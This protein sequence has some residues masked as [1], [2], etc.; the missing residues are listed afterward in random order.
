[1]DGISSVNFKRK[2]IRKIKSASVTYKLCS[3][4]KS[5]IT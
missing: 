2:R 5:R 3:L 1:M 4:Y